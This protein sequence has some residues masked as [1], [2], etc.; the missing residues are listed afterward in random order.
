M[1]DR[2]L[3]E[4][5]DRDYCGSKLAFGKSTCSFMF[6]YEI[7]KVIYRNVSQLKDNHATSSD[8][9]TDLMGGELLPVATSLSDGNAGYVTRCNLFS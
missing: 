3:Y 6:Q 7:S 8:S 9:S 2:L 5:S 1:Y 4:H